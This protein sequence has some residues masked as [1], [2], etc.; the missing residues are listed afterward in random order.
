[1]LK[2]VSLD[3]DSLSVTNEAYPSYFDTN[4]S[5]AQTIGVSTVYSAK[6]LF[7]V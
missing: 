4:I 6:I 3:V 7:A 2:I 5:A 1:M